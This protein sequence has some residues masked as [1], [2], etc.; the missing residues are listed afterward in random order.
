[1]P[2]TKTNDHNELPNNNHY[3]RQKLPNNT[4][5]TKQLKEENQTLKE[6]INKLTR[7]LIRY[8]NPH[9]PPQNASTKPTNNN[10]TKKPKT[11]P[12]Q[13]KRPH[14]HNKN[15]TKNT[16]HHNT[17]PKQTTC[18]C[19]HAPTIK[20]THIDHCPIEEHPQDNTDK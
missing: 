7:T 9:T 5:T 16:N 10:K 20:K 17:P 1:L 14:W 3:N 18:N 11:L 4:P 8:K 13:T 12:R 2:T 6:K 19:C 15:K